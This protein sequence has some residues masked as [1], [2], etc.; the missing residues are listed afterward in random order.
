MSGNKISKTQEQV[1]LLIANR[2]LPHT[3]ENE[4][5]QGV[6]LTEGDFKN[7]DIEL[8]QAFYELT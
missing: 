6:T 5:V 1:V 3:I 8:V 7:Q 4:D 2:I